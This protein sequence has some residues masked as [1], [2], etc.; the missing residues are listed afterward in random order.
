VVINASFYSVDR[1]GRSLDFT[2]AGMAKGKL[3]GACRPAVWHHAARQYS[4]P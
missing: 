3:I 4:Q 1:V 2:Q